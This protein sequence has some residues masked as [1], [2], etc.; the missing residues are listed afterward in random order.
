M[1]FDSSILSKL[2]K[3]LDRRH[4]K[5]LVERYEADAYDKHFSSWQHLVALVFAQVTGADS[6][7][8]IETGFNAQS[9]LHYHL[10]C[11]RLSRSTLADANARRPSSLFSGVL[12]RLLGGLGRKQ[13][14]AARAGLRLIDSTPIK[15]GEMFK[16]PTATGRTRGLKLHVQHDLN[17]GMPVTT[18]ITA[19][20]VNDVHFGVDLALEKGLTYVFDKAYCDYAWWTKINETGAFFVTR[21]KTNLRWMRQTPRF[22]EHAQGDGFEVL[23]DHD[24]V[25]KNQGNAKLDMPLRRIS[26][27]RNVDQ[28]DASSSKT[29]D[30]I[31]NDMN[32]SALDIATCYKAR[33][34]IE[35]LFKWVK[36]NLNIKTFIARNENA[37]RLQI[38]AAMIAFVL[39][40]IARKTANA[41]AH[42]NV[43][44]RRFTELAA[45]FIHTRRDI[46]QIDKPPPIKP[47]KAKSLFNQNQMEL[48]YA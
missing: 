47:S 12:E 32:R 5:S 31:S 13:R 2:L 16:W 28:V 17:T 46:N 25:H 30:I 36:Q 37:V 48:N 24:V 45:S 6:L 1:H 8:A 10:N 27:R 44:Q 35:L 41:L 19:A 22:L 3:P 34:Q 20:T 9:H 38:L 23:S 18:E 4:F 26:I 15:L 33:W 21:P 11:D 7:R 40:A 42:T 43:S 29:F 14:K 39:L